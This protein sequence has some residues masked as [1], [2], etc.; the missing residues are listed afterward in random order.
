M[1]SS[2]TSISSTIIETLINRI[3]QKGLHLPAEFN[4]TNSKYLEKI[5]ILGP[6]AR[7]Q[8][9]VSRLNRNVISPVSSLR[10]YKP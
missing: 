3:Q 8:N 4:F 2:N 6:V 10:V 1:L 7:S 5:Y 9:G